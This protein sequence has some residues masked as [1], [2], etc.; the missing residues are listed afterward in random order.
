MPGDDKVKKGSQTN[1][2]LKNQIRSSNNYSQDFEG[3]MNTMSTEELQSLL[4]QVNDPE[5][6]SPKKT[7]N[8]PAT[9]VAEDFVSFGPPSSEPNKEQAVVPQ[10]DA[11]E[12]KGSAVGPSS[13]SKTNNTGKQSQANEQV[14]EDTV[15][16]DIQQILAEKKRLIE[17]NILKLHKNDK[18][19][20]DKAKKPGWLEEYLR[21]E[22]GQ[23]DLKKVLSNKEFQKEQYDFDARVYKT[24]LKQRDNNFQKL[25]WEQDK[26]DNHVKTKKVTNAKGE[27]IATLTETTHKAKPV[28]IKLEN[29]NEVKVDSYRTVEFPDKLEK[30][31]G[32]MHVALALKDSKGNN[33]A[34]DKALYFTAHYDKEGKLKEVTAPQP[35]KFSGEGKDA[36][37]YIE[38]DGEIYTMPVNRGQY[39]KMMKEVEKNKGVSAS[40]MLRPEGKANAVAEKGDPVKE[41][42]EAQ[43]LSNNLI[44]SQSPK[45][46]PSKDTSELKSEQKENP[47]QSQAVTHNDGKGDVPQSLPKLDKLPDFDPSSVPPPDNTSILEKPNERPLSPSP[48]APEASKE[49]NEHTANG[50]GSLP[51]QEGN[52]EKQE[53]SNIAPIDLKSLEQNVKDFNLANVPPPYNMENAQQPNTSPKVAQGQNA[54]SGV[55]PEDTISPPPEEMTSKFS[56]P[57]AA[58]FEAELVQDNIP[59]PPSSPGGDEIPD[60]PPPPPPPF[61]QAIS[62]APPIGSKP[63]EQSLQEQINGVKLKSAKDG[64]VSKK[65]GAVSNPNDLTGVLSGAI[66]ARQKKMGTDESFADKIEFAND[67]SEIVD[68]LVPVIKDG[69]SSK[70]Q[71]ALKA[72][73][74]VQE[75]WDDTDKLNAEDYKKAAEEAVNRS[76]GLGEGWIK[77]LRR[78]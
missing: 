10:K 5:F 29:G 27:E 69:D 16:K 9:D 21:G 33:I 14:S 75:T 40:I 8:T 48:V 24:L 37:G 55:S 51:Q 49:T 31:S 22:D 7:V 66:D 50:G 43:K 61:E 32:P 64:G 35:I 65:T 30:D 26:N 12:E 45:N 59:P 19:F 28:S 17:E 44:K 34:E 47:S 38:K 73:N 62:D 78:G 2:E 11:K 72:I 18:R 42:S 68:E 53:S 13:S 67:K 25:D 4:A 57:P 77:R 41:Q 58:A 15:E 63:Q 1:D 39:E 20:E 3:A 70:V 6:A 60:A 74:K 71:E 56:P 52:V 46:E 36:V 54:T 76:K 23:K